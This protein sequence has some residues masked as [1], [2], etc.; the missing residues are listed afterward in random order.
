MRKSCDLGSWREDGKPEYISIVDQNHP[1]A[2]GVRNF[3]IPHTEMYDEPFDVPE[4]DAVVFESRWDNGERFRSGCCWK[5]GKGRVFYF[6]PG[7]ETYPIMT[8]E[9]VRL[10]LRNGVAWAARNNC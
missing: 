1:I 4:P 2:A 7:H 8:D 10:I 6:R 3:T 9:N 5:G